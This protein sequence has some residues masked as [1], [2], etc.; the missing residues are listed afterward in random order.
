MSMTRGEAIKILNDE[1]IVSLVGK[2]H[3]GKEALDLAISALRPVSREQD[4]EAE[5][6]ELKK[7]IV[8]WRKY[9]SP[10]R[11]KVEQVWR[12]EWVGSADGY[13]DGELVYDTWT[14][15]KCG[16]VIDEEDDPDMLEK[17]CPKCGA[18]M[19]DEAVDM[20]MERLEALN[21]KD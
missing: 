17:F 16:Y 4:L 8:N 15:S 13:A 6:M 1:E 5:N 12:G 20:V 14:C 9:V 7:R 10:T 21:E 2:F 18:P 11:E 3:G 19:A